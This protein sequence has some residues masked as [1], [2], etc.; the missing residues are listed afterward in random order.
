MSAERDHADGHRR[1]LV[2]SYSLITPFLDCYRTKIAYG[3]YLAA[4]TSSGQGLSGILAGLGGVPAP[5]SFY[6]AARI[7]N[8]G[9]IAAS[10]NLQDGVATHCYASDIANRL[11][12]WATAPSSCTF[13]E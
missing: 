7:Y 9:S 6:E 4:G 13:D 10:G 3:F 2:F 12:G 5:Q 1:K 8:S 11:L